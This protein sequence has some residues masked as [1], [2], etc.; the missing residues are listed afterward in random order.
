MALTL[1]WFA[2]C[3]TSEIVRHHRF[4]DVSA[5]FQR[6]TAGVARPVGRRA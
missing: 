5:L 1:R 4:G 6:W 2:V 3:F